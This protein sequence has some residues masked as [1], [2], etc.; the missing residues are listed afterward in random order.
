VHPFLCSVGAWVCVVLQ[1]LETKWS[2]GQW[3]PALPK[4]QAHPS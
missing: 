1:V 3:G 4:E 2:Q